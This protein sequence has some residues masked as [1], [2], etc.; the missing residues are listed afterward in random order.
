[1]K[2]FLLKIIKYPWKIIK[3]FFC[4]SDGKF[5][6]IYFWTSVCMTLL[7]T[8]WIMKLDYKT[9]INISDT[10]LLGL[11]GFVAI[12]T[13]LYNKQK[14]DAQIPQIPSIDPKTE[15]K[16]KN[17]IDK[18]SQIEDLIKNKLSNK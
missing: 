10:L 11:L 14:K 15:E 8:T 16:F 5:Q 2:S 12:W 9:K 13:A 18:V 4:D 17:I 6:P 7:I 3:E 1:M